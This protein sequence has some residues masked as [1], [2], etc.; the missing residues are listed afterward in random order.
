MNSEWDLKVKKKAASLWSKHRIGNID[1]LRHSP[2]FDVHL[3]LL[4]HFFLNLDPE[5]LVHSLSTK[6]KKYALT[7]EVTDILSTSSFLSYVFNANTLSW[8]YT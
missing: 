5:T 1:H 7:L 2:F 8:K 3:E 4:H 6:F